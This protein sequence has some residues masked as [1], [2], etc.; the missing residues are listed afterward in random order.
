M[1]P[2]EDGDG[3]FDGG[4]TIA[5][6]L[7]AG[8]P[9]ELTDLLIPGIVR[10]RVLEVLTPADAIAWKSHRGEVRVRIDRGADARL[11]VGQVLNGTPPDEHIGARLV[12]VGED[13]AIATID[14]ERFAPGDFPQMPR[15]GIVLANRLQD[16][17]GCPLPVGVALA[18]T[19]TDVPDG[20]DELAW[21]ED[22]FAFFEL[23]I[24]RG[25]RHGLAPGDRL[26]YDPED[27]W[28]AC[29][30]RVQSVESQHATVL[31]RVQRFHP[32][33]E[34]A[35]PGKGDELV[36][37]AWRSSYNTFDSLQSPIPVTAD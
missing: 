13:T 27:D 25:A 34:V 21:D 29:Q 20:A 6:P 16:P 22:G 36:T 32:D 17:I 24:D 7:D 3:G 35:I 12:E 1:T 33:H 4:F 19:V 5:D 31:F 8:L 30:G 11:F 10:A 18:A 28:C 9:A 23:V 37:P 2:V 14:I 26:E 15:P